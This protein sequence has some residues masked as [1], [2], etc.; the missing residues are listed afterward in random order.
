[1]PLLREAGIFLTAIFARLKGDRFQP[2]LANATLPE[3]V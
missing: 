1:M 3:D 2:E